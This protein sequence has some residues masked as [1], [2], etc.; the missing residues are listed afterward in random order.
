MDQFDI[1]LPE[2]LTPAQRDAV[3][4]QLSAPGTLSTADW[5]LALAGFDALRAATVTWAGQTATWRQFYRQ[6]IDEPYATRLLTMIQGADDVER[7]GRQIAVELGRE[8]LVEL[9]RLGGG[10]PQ[11]LS[12]QLLL[13]YCLYWWQSFAKGYILQF[14]VYRDLTASGIQF[15]GVDPLNPEQRYAPDDLI[16]SGWRGDIKASTYFIHTARGAGL[17]HDFYIAR[18]FDSVRHAYRWAVLLKEA[19]WQTLNGEPTPC[20]WNNVP[21]QWPQPAKVMVHHQVLVIVPYE[22]W[23]EKILAYQKGGRHDDRSNPKS[24]GRE[25]I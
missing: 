3:L 12:E 23:K 5:Q 6:V 11:T 22:L 13:A 15:D 24:P 20:D 7:I 19:V 21:R 9:Q 2:A 16:V 18:F 14:A 1:R 4:R 8:I 10:E 25:G 17:S